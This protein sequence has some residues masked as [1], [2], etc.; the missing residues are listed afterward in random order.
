MLHVLYV[1]SGDWELFWNEELG[2]A[3]KKPSM[4]VIFLHYFALTSLQMDRRITV[5]TYALSYLPLLITIHCHLQE[6][7]VVAFQSYHE[8]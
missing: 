6:Q 3:L 1:A 8:M 5:L 7:P 2:N 4:N